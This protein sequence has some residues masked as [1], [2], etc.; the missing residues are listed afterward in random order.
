MSSIDSF[1]HRKVVVLHQDSSAYEAA[2]AMC[3]RRIGCIIVSDHESHIVGIVTDRDLVCSLLAHSSDTKVPLSEV[4]TPKPIM[5]EENVALH[6][7]IDKM[8]VHGIRRIPVVH[9][10]EGAEKRYKCVGIVT[11]DD[12]VASQSIDFDKLTRIVQAQ[13]LRKKS[14]LSRDVRGFRAQVRAE[15][16]ADQTL[17]HF[18]NVISQRTNLDTDTAIKAGTLVL[19]AIVRR[20]HYSGAAHLISQLPKNLQEELLDL[21]AGP[22]RRIC[23]ISIFTELKRQLGFDEN[24]AREIV[25]DFGRA[26][27]ELTGQGQFD[28]AMAQLPDDLR[29]L[30]TAHRSKEETK[31]A[32]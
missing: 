10:L 9:R 23:A 26:L 15:A 13:L 20:M 1:I 4:M 7:V 19:S 11:L 2:R 18:F 31:F 28:H 5:V 25:T 3:D 32:A 24:Q 30:F 27:E 21:P 16:R 6:D 17:N 12:L 14:P 8:V 29:C 22:D